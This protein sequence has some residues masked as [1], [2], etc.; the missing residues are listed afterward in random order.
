MS[1]SNGSNWYFHFIIIK[2]H[3]SASSLR[4]SPTQTAEEA[5]DYLTEPK[6]GLKN[7]HEQ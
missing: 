5:N 7:A 4:D 3:N 1:F 2:L 6:Q